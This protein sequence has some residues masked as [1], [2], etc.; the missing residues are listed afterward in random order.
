MMLFAHL[1]PGYIAAD[2]SQKTWP[3]EWSANR[4]LLLWAV[5]LVST[6]APDVDV[7]Y[8]ARFQGFINHSWLWTHSLFLY[9]GIGLV[10]WLLRRDGRWPY[11]QTLVGLIAFGGMSHLA[12]DVAS[13]GT[14]LLYPL[15]MIT[16]GGLSQRVVHGD[17]WAYVTDPIYLLEPLLFMLAALYWVWQRP[18]RKAW[19]F[20][21]VIGFWAVYSTVLLSA[22]FQGPS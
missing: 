20:A 13:H 16:V 22:M 11:G 17:L 12:L 3:A 15:S 21:L 10:W 14:P 8:N 4:R 1:V 18:N 9:L 5:A 19:M 2:R 6:V 7:I